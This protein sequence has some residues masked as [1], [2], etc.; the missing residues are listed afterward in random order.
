MI[1]HDPAM[2]R[3][4]LDIRTVS[5]KDRSR[6]QVSDKSIA[7][8]MVEV[9]ELRRENERLNNEVV[10]LDA[11]TMKWQKQLNVECTATFLLGMELAKKENEVS[12]LRKDILI[13]ADRLQKCSEC[14]GKAAERRPEVMEGLKDK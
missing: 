1:E 12:R 11:L 13:V 14:L 8:L 7:R 6:S 2:L 5:D 3:Q 9:E 4:M 10:R